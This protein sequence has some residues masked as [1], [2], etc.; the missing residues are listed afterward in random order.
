MRIVFSVCKKS[1]GVFE[2]HVL[3]TISFQGFRGSC[4]SETRQSH[5]VDFNVEASR[6]PLSLFQFMMLCYVASI[7]TYNA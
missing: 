2:K 5:Y 6:E 7:H 1:R 4:R 3:N